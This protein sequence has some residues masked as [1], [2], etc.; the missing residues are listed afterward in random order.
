MCKI[1]YQGKKRYLLQRMKFCK[2][3]AYKVPGEQKREK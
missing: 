1:L 2:T 3:S